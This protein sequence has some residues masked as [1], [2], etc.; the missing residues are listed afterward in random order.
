MGRTGLLGGPGLWVNSS[1][2]TGLLGGPGLWV[3]SSGGSGL[4]GVTGLWVNSSGGT[5]LLGGPGLWVNSSVNH[6]AF[7]PQ[8]RTTFP[9]SQTPTGSQPSLKGGENTNQVMIKVHSIYT[10]AFC[11]LQ[12]PL[13]CF[14]V[15]SFLHSHGC[16]HT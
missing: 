15:Q 10:E 5:G 4:L 13:W 14:C 16:W 2:G 11:Y 8:Q 1:G 7:L 12:K 3:N 9:F 6:L